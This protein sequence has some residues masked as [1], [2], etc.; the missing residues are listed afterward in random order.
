MTDIS[1]DRVIRV[2]AKYFAQLGFSILAEGG[3]QARAFRYR[4]PDGRLKFPD[5]AVCGFGEL[6][7]FE[8]KARA[9]GLFVRSALG[10][11]DFEC[12]RQASTDSDSLRLLSEEACLRME[13]CGQ[14]TSDPP[15]AKMGLLT[16]SGLL[17]AAGG[18]DLHGLELVEAEVITCR[19]SRL[20]YPFA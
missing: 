20:T 6:L 14:G 1:E 15:V 11:S 7:V 17:Q 3:N 2:A 10:F 18:E 4:S 9:A 19:V 16:S 8:A 12:V 13:A 5:L